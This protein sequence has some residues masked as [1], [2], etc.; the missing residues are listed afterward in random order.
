MYEG[1]KISGQK[2]VPVNDIESRWMYNK[3]NKAELSYNLK[4]CVDCATHIILATYITQNP[5][6]SYDLLIVTDLAMKN[7]G[8]TFKYLLVDSGY[9]NELVIAYLINTGIEGFIPNATQ[10]R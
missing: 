7:V 10:S 5:S 8:S 1:L 2:S 4:T 3:K 6:D 9:C